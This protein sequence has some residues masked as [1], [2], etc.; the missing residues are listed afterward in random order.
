[1]KR[2]FPIASMIAA[3]L[4]SA[5]ALSQ[6]ADVKKAGGMLVTSSGMTVYTFDKDKT[7]GSP[8]ACTGGCTGLWPA[9]IATDSKPQAPYGAITREDGSMQVTYKGKP[10]YVFSGDKKAGDAAGDNFKDVWHTVKD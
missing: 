3:L 7:D 5:T 1:M 4:L 6:A 10:L 9:V 2:T 8:S